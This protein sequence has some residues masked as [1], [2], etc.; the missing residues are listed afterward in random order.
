MGFL[1]VSHRVTGWSTEPAPPSAAC[2][3][4][5]LSVVVEPNVLRASKGSRALS[6]I[7]HS[8][9]ATVLGTSPHLLPPQL[10]SRAADRESRKKHAALAAGTTDTAMPSQPVDY[11][12]LEASTSVEEITENEFS[13]DSLWLLKNDE[14]P[15]LWLCTQDRNDEVGHYVVGNRKE[16]GW[17]GHFVKKSTGLKWFGMY[18]YGI[19]DKCSEQSVDRFFADL[20]K[21]SHIEKM[22]FEGID[23]AGFIYKLGNAIKISKYQRSSKGCYLGVPEAN[24]LSDTFRAMK[25]LKELWIGDD[26]DSDPVDHDLN[27]EDVAECI[28]LL[29]CCAGMRKLVLKDMSMSTNSCAAISA[30]FHC[31]TALLELDLGGNSINNASVEVLV[32]GLTECKHLH[33]LR[34]GGNMIGDDGLDVLVQGLPAS[35]DDLGL[36][37]NGITLARQLS[38]LRFKTLH[39]AENALSS[40][41]ARVLAAS[42]ANPECRLERLHLLFNNIG[43]EGAAIIATSLRSNQRLTF[44][45]LTNCN[46]T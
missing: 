43:D 12:A 13:Q 19:F 31:M 25:S 33:S 26:E 39:L 46:I 30:I 10:P 22:T 28:P 6:Y 32:R 1:I 11:D 37:S 18:G 40:G 2:A 17:L 3:Q 20:G 8:Q 29:A 36:S 16:L 14:L 27:D 21:C 24:H 15:A 38:L 35:V 4:L 9:S 42:L 23:L 41:G 34:L 5:S 7:R 44:L 45:S